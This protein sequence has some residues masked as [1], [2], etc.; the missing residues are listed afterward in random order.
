[1]YGKSLSGGLW[2]SPELLFAT[3]NV[4]VQIRDLHWGRQQDRVLSQLHPELRCGGGE[5]VPV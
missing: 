4:I 5:E 1:M 3:K 2:D